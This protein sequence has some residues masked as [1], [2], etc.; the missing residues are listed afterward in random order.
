MLESLTALAYEQPQ[1]ARPARIA[2]LALVSLQKMA[3]A[4]MLAWIRAWVKV[5]STPWAVVGPRHRTLVTR[6]A[7]GMAGRKSAG[8]EGRPQRDAAIAATA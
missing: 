8:S 6:S 3:S 5:L 1:F 4:R 7:L 2:Q